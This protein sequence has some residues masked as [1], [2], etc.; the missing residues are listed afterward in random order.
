MDEVDAERDE[1]IARAEEEAEELV[2]VGRFIDPS[3]AQMAKGMLEAAGIDCFI[4][5]ENANALMAGIFRARIE[6]RKED[7]P[8]ARALME[9]ANEA[10]PPGQEDSDLA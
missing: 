2:M 4:Q 9:S 3:E 1:Q 10:T 5:G 8:A 7:E 6:V